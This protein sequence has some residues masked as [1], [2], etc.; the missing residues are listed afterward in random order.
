MA[1]QLRRGLESDRLSITPA[2]GEPIVTEQGKLYVG[3]GT[4]PGGILISGG[5]GGGSG[6]QNVVEDTSPQLGGNLDVNGHS[7]VSTSNANINITPNG[8]GNIVLH[9]DLIIDP[10]G[11][12]TKTGQLNITPTTVLSIG[13]N[14]TLADGNL[15]ITRNSYTTTFTQGFV[16]AQ[17]H[18]TAD[19]VNFAFYRSRGTG[20]V[21]AAVINGDD[22]ADISFV[23][24][25]G[26]N[27]A[28][29][30]AISATV[31]GTPTL[32]HVPTKLS[33]V[34]DNGTAIGVRAE[35]SAAGVWKTNSIQNYSGTDLT[36][37]A[38]N[39][40]I[41]GDVQLNA[42][43][44]L[45]FADSDSSN[46][47]AFQSPATVAS[48]VTWTLPSADGVNGQVLS[49]N[50]SGVL[51]WTSASGGGTLSSRTL[52]SGTTSSINDGAA[53][54]L[55][56]SGY[57]G[58]LLY[59]IQTSGAA[60]V[61]LYTDDANRT[62]DASRPE[63]SDPLPGAGVIAEVITTG[64]QLILI[65][66]GAIGFSFDGSGN[67]T[68]TIFA[69]VTNKTGSTAAITVSLRVVQVEA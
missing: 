17:H 45:K 18:T 33:F 50:G 40:K 38:T 11:N 2:V 35:L 59:A 14:S 24:H 68:T 28:N 60:W 19:A 13:N 26:T 6:I 37:T 23:G 15:Y 54:N 30:A 9:G 46:Y 1:L 66:P 65:S 44:I 36:L 10:V 31:E 62:S 61:R 22:L 43:H 5:G 49:T 69:R 47:V 41:V 7:I 34:T 56:I 57:K 64:A 51:S 29:G 8:T 55:D 48:N 16:F 52:V 39:V 32:G 21:P 4:T 53:T 58:Y 12:I 27:R 42:Q 3:D 20:S 63:G 67:A 25:D